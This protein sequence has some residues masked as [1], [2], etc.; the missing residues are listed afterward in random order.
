MSPD[1]FPAEAVGMGYPG[2]APGSRTQGPNFEFSTL[3][4]AKMQRD[5]NPHDTGVTKALRF[6]LSDWKINKKRGAPQHTP[7]RIAVPKC[8]PGR[9]IEQRRPCRIGGERGRCELPFVVAGDVDGMD[10]GAAA[11]AL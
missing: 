2:G 1:T 5:Q 10:S 3:T 9:S 6:G 4:G 11:G 8:A 7:D